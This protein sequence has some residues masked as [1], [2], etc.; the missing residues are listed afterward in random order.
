M[1]WLLNYRVIRL[2]SLLMAIAS[3]AH[4]ESPHQLIE[5]EDRTVLIAGT[6]RLVHDLG[7][8]GYGEDPKHDAHVSYWA[9]E[10]P[11]PINT[12][13]TPE[14]T[15]F[16]GDC[17]AAKRMKLFFE[18]FELQP[19]NKLP[20]AKWNNRPVVVRGKLHRADTAGEM[21]VIY[22]D[23]STIRPANDTKTHD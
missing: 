1:V 23:V 11:V 10:T 18:G 21:T 6:I 17:S 5:P 3:T 22:M 14:K 20:A 8:P 19:L 15:E 4:T 9:L 16:T 12:P 2:I 13:C 7:P